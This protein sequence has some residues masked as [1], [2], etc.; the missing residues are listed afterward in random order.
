MRASPHGGLSSGLAAARYHIVAPERRCASQQKLRA[1]VA[2]GS[3]LGPLTMSAARPSSTESGS[4]AAILLYR[5]RAICYLMHRSTQH[6]YLTHH[7]GSNVRPGTHSSAFAI[8]SKVSANSASSG[9]R[10]ATNQRGPQVGDVIDSV[11]RSGRI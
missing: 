6:R 1:D 7:G 11:G 5:K 8:S 4:P 9:A 2:D 3:K 10:R